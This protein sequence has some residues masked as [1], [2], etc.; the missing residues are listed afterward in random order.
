MEHLPEN[1]RENRVRQAAEKNRQRLMKLPNVVGVGVGNKEVGG[2]PTDELAVVVLVESKVPEARLAGGEIVPKKVGDV[3][4]DVIEVGQLRAL[5]PEGTAAARPGDDLSEHRRLR[6]P[7]CPG[8]SVGHWAIT[9]GTFGALVWCRKTGRPMILSNNHVLANSTNGRDGRGKKGDPVLQPGAYDMGL[10]SSSGLSGENLKKLQIAKLE[11]YVPFRVRKPNLVDCAVARPLKP[12]LI[13]DEIVGLGRVQGVGEVQPGG[14]VRKSGRTTGLTESRVRVLHAS[15]RV[16]YPQGSL[17][18][19]NQIVC[20]YMS[21]G[22]D[23]GSLVLDSANRAV[24]LLFAG[25]ERAT[26]LNPIGAVLEALKIGFE[27]E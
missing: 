26:I 17:A 15:V 1:G 10:D 24:G 18:F 3:A 25:S 11:R 4:T 8:M 21:E 5:P 12:E 23:S 2:R 9:A 7:A 19:E 6:R 13:S 22:G 20:G 16:A 14:V 27:R